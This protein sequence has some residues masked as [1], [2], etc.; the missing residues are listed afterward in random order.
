ML[1]NEKAEIN[2]PQLSQINLTGL[3]QQFFLRA[4]ASL[5]EK[6]NNITTQMTVA[7]FL[8]VQPLDPFQ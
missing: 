2:Q 5:P 6:A 4:W 1:N 3:P 8:M 7:N